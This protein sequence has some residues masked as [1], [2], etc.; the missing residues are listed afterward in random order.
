MHSYNIGLEYTGVK[1]CIH[2][3]IK[4]AMHWELSGQNNPQ[5]SEV[6]IDSLKNDLQNVSKP[7]MR[8]FKGRDQTKGLDINKSV[9]F[10]DHPSYIPSRVWI[11]YQCLPI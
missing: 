2:I 11:V 4:A 5:L 1:F 10:L 8:T 6:E 3:L 9:I 7:R